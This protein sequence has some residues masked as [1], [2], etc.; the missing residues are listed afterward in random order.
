MA[1]DTGSYAIKI[2]NYGQQVLLSYLGCS[3]TY[4]A[5]KLVKA[6]HP[7][8]TTS[9]EWSTCSSVFWPRASSE[10]RYMFV[11]LNLYSHV[12]SSGLSVVGLIL[13]EHNPLLVQC[14]YSGNIVLNT[15]PTGPRKGYILLH[16]SAV[17]CVSQVCVESG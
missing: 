8:W 13:L 14:M 2:N 5:L 4:I 17:Q 6:C 10:Q 7:I 1:R 11:Q 16:P 15:S 3:D 12:A 9:T